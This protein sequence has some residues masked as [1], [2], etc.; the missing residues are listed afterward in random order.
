MRHPRPYLRTL[1]VTVAVIAGL[2]TTGAVAFAS[3]QPSHTQP[4]Q[5]Q[6]S[7]A[8]TREAEHQGAGLNPFG[9]C[10]GHPRRG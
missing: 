3:T 9:A 2:A 5:V 7:N 4:T 1:M 10:H 8:Q 6:L